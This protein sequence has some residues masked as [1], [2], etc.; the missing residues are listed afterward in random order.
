MAVTR[1]LS[2]FLHRRERY[3]SYLYI[4][5]L[6]SL[7]PLPWIVHLHHEAE[8]E[9]ADQPP[10]DSHA[11]QV[12]SFVWFHLP[13]HSRFDLLSAALHPHMGIFQLNIRVQYPAHGQPMGRHR[14]FFRIV[15]WHWEEQNSNLR[16]LGSKPKQLKPGSAGETCAQQVVL[17]D[18]IWIGRAVPWAFGYVSCWWAIQ[19]NCQPPLVL[20]HPIRGIKREQDRRGCSITFQTC[21]ALGRYGEWSTRTLI[22]SLNGTLA[23]YIWESRL[24]STALREP[25][26]RYCAEIVIIFTSKTKS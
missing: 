4:L 26:W 23:Y 18:A 21:G 2:I 8:Q 14:G 10:H 17:G 24:K 7:F 13:P 15:F 9:T 5:R 6:E 16:Y 22:E 1:N 25:R 20:Y 11:T 3:E 12:H 19:L